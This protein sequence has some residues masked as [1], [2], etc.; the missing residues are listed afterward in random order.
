MAFELFKWGFV[1][2]MGLTWLALGVGVIMLLIPSASDKR[3][4][5]AA[6]VNKRAA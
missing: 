3:Q 1:V 5:Y 4:T 6:D 2:S